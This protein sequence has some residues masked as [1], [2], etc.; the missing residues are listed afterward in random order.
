[1]VD[2][3]KIAKNKSEP[4]QT[5]NAV[6]YTTTQGYHDENRISLSRKLQNPTITCNKTE[7]PSA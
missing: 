6:S 5:I 1:L 7:A 2:L 4:L 3:I